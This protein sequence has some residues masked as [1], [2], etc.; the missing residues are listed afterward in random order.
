M[1]FRAV[2]SATPSRFAISG[3]SGGALGAVMITT[4][5]AEAGNGATQPCHP[6]ATPLWWKT[7][8]V[9][10][11]RDCLEVLTS[12][13]F[14]SADV[15]GFAFNDMLPFSWSSVRDRAAVLEDS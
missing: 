4:A 3:V 14:L 10:S 13:D 8:K 7:D 6:S 15:L 1:W 11:W 2:S 9:T 12:G 5:F